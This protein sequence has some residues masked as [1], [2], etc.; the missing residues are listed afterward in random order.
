MTELLLYHCL[1]LAL[2]VISP[3]PITYINIHLSMP[4]P[5][6]EDYNG[7]DTAPIQVNTSCEPYKGVPLFLLQKQVIKFVKSSKGREILAL[8][9]Q[10]LTHALRFLP[11]SCLTEIRGTIKLKRK[12]PWACQPC[13]CQRWASRREP[14][15]PLLHLRD[16]ALG[17]AS[18]IP[19]GAF[20]S[21]TAPL[22]GPRRGAGGPARPAVMLGA[23][24]AAAELWQPAGA[25]AGDKG[26]AAPPSPGTGGGL[27]GETGTPAPPALSPA[28]SS[29]PCCD[30]FWGPDGGFLEGSR[31]LK[32]C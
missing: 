1:F 22:L 12:K 24:L 16:L 5:P 8:L 20:S 4:V 31:Q 6:A 15:C 14:P 30:A 26:R 11:A 27:R 29:A 25:R 21:P 10:I 2:C 9:L 32:P 13:Y 28:A 17:D 7:P 23:P 18:S 19:L 3:I